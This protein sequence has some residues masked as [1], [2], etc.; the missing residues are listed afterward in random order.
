MA[1]KHQLDYW[2][3]VKQIFTGTRI[4]TTS[5]TT[6]TT[7]SKKNADKLAEDLLELTKDELH[8]ALGGALAPFDG[9]F[10]NTT[11][12]TGEADF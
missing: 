10:Q 6:A 12:L 8:K 9:D 11:L 1:K 5:T 3:N 2:A 7:L 4:T